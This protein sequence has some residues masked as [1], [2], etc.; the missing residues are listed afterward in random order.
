MEK[1]MID[2]FQCS[3]TIYDDE[4]FKSMQLS[5][6]ML[7][8]QLCRKRNRLEDKDG[9]FYRSLFELA[10]DT[11]MSKKTICIAKKL[12]IQNKLIEVK[13]RYNKNTKIRI[14]DL[15]RINGFKYK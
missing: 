10:I 6:Q 8:T 3:H 15:Y 7:F 14:E 1:T 13:R 4:K 2:Y 9:W 12:L 5:A 11:G